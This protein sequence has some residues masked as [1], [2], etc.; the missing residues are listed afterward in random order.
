MF[1][2]HGSHLMPEGTFSATLTTGAFTQAAYGGLQ[3]AP[4]SRLREA[5][6]YFISHL[7]CCLLRHTDVA[8]P[9]ECIWATT[10]TAQDALG[11]KQNIETVELPN[12]Q[13]LLQPN[14]TK[15]AQRAN[16]SSAVGSKQC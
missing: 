6:C 15:R 10:L 1:A 5:V 9:E 11:A 3:P 13:L 14:Q 16:H 8:S 4:A 2:F 7:L 12:A